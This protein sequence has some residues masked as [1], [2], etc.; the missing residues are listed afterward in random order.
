MSPA[1]L[2]MW[3]S[4]AGM[5]FMFLAVLII[6]LSRFKLKGILKIVAAWLAY[7]L[8]AISGLLIFFILFS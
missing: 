3:I 7:M 2:K 4:I 5:V 8:M 1:L 6:Y